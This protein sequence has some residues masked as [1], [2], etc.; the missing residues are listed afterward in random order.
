MSP[1]RWETRY[2]GECVLNVCGFNSHW[3]GLSRPSAFRRTVAPMS[4][5]DDCMYSFRVQ[6]VGTKKNRG[7]SVD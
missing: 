5:A 2:V 3:A 7:L 6:L 4:F 1:V